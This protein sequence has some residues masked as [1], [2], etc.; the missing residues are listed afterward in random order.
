VQ[1]IALRR[2]ADHVLVSI[3]AEIT[4]QATAPARLLAEDSSLMTATEIIPAF[5]RPFLESP[6]MAA[7]ATSTVKLEYWADAT[8]LKDELR[9]KYKSFSQVVKSAGEFPTQQL[10][11]G[12]SVVLSWPAWQKR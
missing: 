11:E 4:N 9:L 3:T 12:E 2:D 10:P 8:Q 6:L 1:E 5:T 7:G